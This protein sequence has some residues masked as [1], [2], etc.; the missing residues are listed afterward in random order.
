MDSWATLAD[1]VELAGA[2]GG[3]V[4]VSGLGGLDV[5]GVI[6]RCTSTLNTRNEKCD[7]SGSSRYLEPD[8][9]RYIVSLI[10]NQD[11]QGCSLTQC[12]KRTS[13]A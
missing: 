13:E 1:A 5:G 12:P 2:G 9:P 6:G 7:L 10:I 11:E 4:G 8:M 3:G